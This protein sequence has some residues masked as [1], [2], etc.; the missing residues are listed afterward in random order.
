MLKYRPHTSLRF[1]SLFISLLQSKLECLSNL[2][3]FY[4]LDK[5][6]PGSIKAKWREPKSCLGQIFNFKLCCFCCEC[7]CTAYTRMPTSGANVKKL[8][9]FVIYGFSYLARV[10]VIGKLFWSSLTNTLA[11]HE[12]P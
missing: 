11:Y 12:N 10:F 9:L 5:P 3:I 2:I 8:F 7:K 6:I 1:F 4:R